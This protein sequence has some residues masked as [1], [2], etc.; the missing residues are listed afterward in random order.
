[1]LSIALTKSHK[2]IKKEVSHETYCALIMV[3]WMDI[4]PIAWYDLE[5]PCPCSKELNVYRHV[6]DN[7]V[8]WNLPVGI[9]HEL[10]MT[11]V[12]VGMVLK[13]VL[14]FPI[15]LICRKTPVNINRVNSVYVS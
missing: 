5:V 3:C 2:V 12:A 9:I 7:T 1:M 8:F 11:L 13:I 4:G 15:T 6:A 10:I 14:K